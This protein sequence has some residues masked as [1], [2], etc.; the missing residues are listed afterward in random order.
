MR[1]I[2]I[3]NLPGVAEFP[4]LIEMAE[5]V[6]GPRFQSRN[7]RNYATPSS[8]RFQPARRFLFVTL[9]QVQ[10]NSADVRPKIE[11][12]D[13]EEGHLLLFCRGVARKTFLKFRRLLANL[14]PVKKCIG[15][16]KPHAE[17]A[18]HFFLLGSFSSVNLVVAR[19]HLRAAPAKLRDFED[20]RRGRT[21]ALCREFAQQFV[22]PNKAHLCLFERREVQQVFELLFIPAL[23]VC[24]R[25]ENDSQP[26][27]E[28]HVLHIIGG[29][30]ARLAV[31][32]DEP[33]ANLLD[34]RGRVAWF[35]QF[36]RNG[37]NHL[38]LRHVGSVTLFSTHAW[39]PGFFFALR[40]C[41]WLFF[42][43]GLGLSL[44][45]AGGGSGGSP[46]F[47]RR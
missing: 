12:F 15:L 29:S 45:G 47:S 25:R 1:S 28:E 26:R 9:D 17:P 40:V 20:A 35:I 27:F 2:T 19:D 5:E 21:L 18:G 23:R 6:E 24:M 42:G 37:E 41:L 7:G 22:Q 46:S 8:C 11:R 16:F 4:H 30:S 32:S 36:T 3:R 39:R 13:L 10:A 44:T 33:P 43:A 31:F 38:L 34:F 14:E